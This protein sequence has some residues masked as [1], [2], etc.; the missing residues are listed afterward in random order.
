M[1]IAI[2]VLLASLG[3]NHDVQLQKEYLKVHAEWRRLH[4]APNAEAQLVVD[5]REHALWIEDRGNVHHNSVVDLPRG[6]RWYAFHVTSVGIV[7]RS[8]PV[9][10]THA[11]KDVQDKSQEEVLWV[12]GVGKNRS[13]QF[14][15]AASQS[16]GWVF[17]VGSGSPVKEITFDLPDVSPGENQSIHRSFLARQSPF[18]KKPAELIKKPE[19]NLRVVRRAEP[20]KAD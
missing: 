5:P 11:R 15:F 1:G 18:Q 2:A 20:R 3:A 14:S 4:E 19:F 6:C 9:R 8:F 10:L 12:I 13:W 7:E 17:H 16:S